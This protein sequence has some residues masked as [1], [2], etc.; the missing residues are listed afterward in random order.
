[1]KVR[2]ILMAWG[3]G[4]LALGSIS[5][6]AQA[7]STATQMLR[8]SAFGGI[9]GTYTGLAGGRNVGI[10]AGADLSFRPFFSLR[11]SVEVRG[12]Y[13]VH[14]DG[15]D[16]QRNGLVGIKLERAFGRLRPYGDA[17]FGRGAIDYPHGFTD[18]TGAR[19][20]ARTV[21]NVF[22]FGGGVDYDLTPH[23]A[24]KADVQV[25]RYVTP[26]T[27]SGNVYA[28]SGTAGIVYR[29]D[30]NHHPRHLR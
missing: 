4:L 29:F 8:L 22:A 21:S 20:Y 19:T 12:T 16:S 10:T 25:I 28:K 2:R 17:L 18:P 11:P 6:A 30:F 3:A 27:V 14:D 15:I 7:R 13:P 9:N 1:V 26:V 23:F 24:L 5:A